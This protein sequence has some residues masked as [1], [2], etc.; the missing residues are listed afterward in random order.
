MPGTASISLRTALALVLAAAVVAIYGPLRSH[1]FIVLDDPIYVAN[2]PHVRAGLTRDGVLW[3]LR[4]FDF[5]WHPLTW[6]SHM[7]DVEMFGIDP[8]LHLLVNAAWHLATTLLVYTVF[9]RMTGMAVRSAAVAALFAV[10]PMH[11]EPVAWLSERKEL[12]A[13]FFFAVALHAYV[14][15]VRRRSAVA[16]IGTAAALAAGLAA[17]GT[18]VTFPF[19]LLLLDV[20]P[21]RRFG[22][23][24]AGRIV[25]EKLPLLVIAAGG[26]AVTLAAQTSVGAV[27]AAVPV[28]V[29]A[30]NAVQ[31][32][33]KYLWK[34]FAPVGL[35]IPYPYSR[36]IDAAAVVAAVAALV[37]VVVLAAR[38]IRT[39]PYVFTGVFWFLGML[40]PMIG[41]V[42]I[43]TQ[44]M[45]DRYT[46][47]PHIGLFAA[48]VW[49]AGDAIP[50][51]R[52]FR[53]IAG[54]ATIGLLAAA[55]AL[56]AKQVGYWHDGVRLF[57]HTL[58]VTG[59]NHDASVL[60]GLTYLQRFDFAAAAEQ[61]RA[62][63]R[64]QDSDAVA[65]TGLGIAL[66][67]MGDTEHA[68]RELRRAVA[69]TPS[70]ADGW[71]NL[72][73]LELATGR[74]DAARA[75]YEQAVRLSGDARTRAG[76]AASSGQLATALELYR[77]AIAAEPDSPDLRIELARALAVNGLIAPAREQDEIALR[78]APNRYDA[79]MDLAALLI[80]SGAADAAVA[81]LEAASSLAPASPEP[82]VYLSL[83][84]AAAGRYRIAAGEVERAVRLDP[85]LANAQFTE[86]TGS[87]PSPGNL[88]E[89]ERQLRSK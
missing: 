49:L 78:I 19:V 36:H 67:R 28:S 8:G 15:F 76:L 74:F 65:H 27:A 66:R 60:L 29:R 52:Q 70:L 26:V 24:P 63:T 25:V 80:Q 72:G 79:R 7:L 2:N 68:R 38:S 43:G 20:W 42:Q 89:F 62:A 22:R 85:V 3:A 48:V 82:H 31:S 50:E 33:A 45:A 54:C 17:K 14:T 40:V 53:V 34:T 77:S 51:R 11:V 61:F 58:A 69:I 6:L 1:T 87:T 55:T 30:A 5:N 75:A 35:A 46:Y 37:V 73:E 56:S 23:E 13:G 32:Y 21:L 44:P 64:L 81:Q 9:V 4:S 88:F 57:R 47:L 71:R 41:L 18:L 16:Y 84:H 39:Q 83:V 10:H 59:P 86:I 12:L